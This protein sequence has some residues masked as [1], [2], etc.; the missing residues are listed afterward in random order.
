MFWFLAMV[1]VVVEM[2]LGQHQ[3]Q[4]LSATSMIRFILVQVD[5]YCSPYGH[6]I[7]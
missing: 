1:V 4:V 5:A 3:R 7:D 6:I 2:M